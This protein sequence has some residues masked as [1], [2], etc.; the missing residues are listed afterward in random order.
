MVYQSPKSINL[1]QLTKENLMTA[2]RR[3]LVTGSSRGIGKAIA[4]ALAKDGFD[5]TVHARSRMDEALATVSEITALGRQS[6]AL[7]FDVNDR[8]TVHDILSA[9]MD[10]HG[11]Y[12]GVVLNA[13]LNLDGAFPALSD[14]DWDSVVGTSLNGFY[15]VLKPITMPMVRAKQGGR[16]VTLASVSG[17][18]GNR[19][20]VNYSGAKAGLIGATKALAL[21]LATRNITVNCVAPGLI[22]TEM[23]NEEVME[24]ALPMIPMKRA[25]VVDDVA[26]LVAFLCSDKAGYITRQVVSVNGGMV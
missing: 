12:Y 15:N 5:V 26:D 19:G 20:Q 1:T 4:L 22:D 13:G 18:V 23:V 14:D 9:D 11:A 7:Q 3:I 6:H 25:G 21:E 24:R 16:I 8:T 10:A 2:N 17:L